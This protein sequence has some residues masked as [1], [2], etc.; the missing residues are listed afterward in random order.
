MINLN[1][2]ILVDIRHIPEHSRIRATVCYGDTVFAMQKVY[3]E[4]H[5]GN[6]DSTLEEL[7]DLRDRFTR[8]PIRG[9]TDNEMPILC[10]PDELFGSGHLLADLARILDSSHVIG[11]YVNKQET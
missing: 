11:A 7:C 3:L 8:I 6:P 5:Y 9:T 4:G 2:L 1:D 10:T